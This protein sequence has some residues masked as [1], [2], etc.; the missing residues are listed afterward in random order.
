MTITMAPPMTQDR[1][2]A[3]PAIWEAYSAPNNQPEPMIAPTPVNSRL[4][5]PTSRHSPVSSRTSTLWGTSVGA[6]MMDSSWP[7]QVAAGR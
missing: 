6:A 7:T 2:A 3:G 5:L 1:I 4:V